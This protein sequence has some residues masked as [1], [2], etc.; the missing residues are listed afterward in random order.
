LKS[1]ASCKAQLLVYFE[2]MG[3]D[4]LQMD[5]GTLILLRKGE[6]IDFVIEI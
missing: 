1:I 3:V 2:E 5:L 6:E 4:R